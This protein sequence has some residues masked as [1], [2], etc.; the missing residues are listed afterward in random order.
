MEQIEYFQTLFMEH[1]DALRAQGAAAYMR[2]NFAFYGIPTPLRRSLY[3]DLLKEAKR[4]KVI[5]WAFVFECWQ[6]PQREWQYLALDYLRTMTRSLTLDDLPRL[7]ILARSK[8]WWDS[9]DVLDRIIGS[10][11]DPALDTVMRAWAADP[12]FWIRRIAID[13]QLARKSKTKPDLLAEI[14]C[15]NLGDREFFINKAIGWSLREYSKTNPDWVR[16]FVEAHRNELAPL[17]LR[18]ASKYFL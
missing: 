5:D 11:D 10:I 2:N 17:S 3:A 12:D 9:I 15:M 7:E 13:H 1:A 18:E 4:G 16:A 14:I 8:Q 6:Q